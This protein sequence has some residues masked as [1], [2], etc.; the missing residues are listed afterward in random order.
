M[1]IQGLHGPC[2]TTVFSKTDDPRMDLTLYLFNL[3]D[4]DVHASWLWERGEYVGDIIDGQG[5]SN[6]YTLNGYFVEVNL[7]DEAGRD[8]RGRAVKHR[9]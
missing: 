3:L 9:G 2:A 4:M 8:R 6:Y 5:R 7:F 1:P